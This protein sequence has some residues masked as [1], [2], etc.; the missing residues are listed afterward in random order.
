MGPLL[1]Q[2]HVPSEA[3]FTF[4]LV[5][6]QTPGGKGEGE[7]VGV[8]VGVIGKGTHLLFLHSLPDPQTIV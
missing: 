5:P 3:A 1:D 4:K 6:W 8:G 2:G 7:G